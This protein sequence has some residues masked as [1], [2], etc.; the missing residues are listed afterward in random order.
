MMSRSEIEALPPAD[1]SA[2]LSTVVSVK[3]QRQHAASAP[4]ILAA[5]K[6]GDSYIFDWPDV[7]RLG[8]KRVKARQRLDDPNAHWQGRSTTKGVRV[9]RIR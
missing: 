4:A 8:Q 7:S 1:F 3:M 6:V 2:L 9:T 5:M